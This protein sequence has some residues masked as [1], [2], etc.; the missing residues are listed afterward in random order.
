M[1]QD[2]LIVV[3]DE[4]DIFNCHKYTDAGYIAIGVSSMD[5][6]IVYHFRRTPFTRFM[7][8]ISNKT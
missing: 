7:T 3:K 5:S 4:I 6:N 1:K 8:W 2:L